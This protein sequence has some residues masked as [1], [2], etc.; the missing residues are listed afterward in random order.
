MDNIITHNF[1]KSVRSDCFKVGESFTSG[2]GVRVHVI[3]E[4][5]TEQGRQLLYSAHGTKIWA[6]EE[7]FKRV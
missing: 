2:D 7:K 6:S 4:R 3:D 5:I 1:R